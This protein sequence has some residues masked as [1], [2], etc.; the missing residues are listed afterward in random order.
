M[1][2]VRAFRLAYSWH[3]YDGHME[4]PPN[5]PNCHVLDAAKIPQDLQYVLWEVPWMKKLYRVARSFDGSAK[6]FFT[7]FQHLPKRQ[8][9]PDL[10]WTNESVFDHME[11]A[12]SP[13][14]GNVVIDV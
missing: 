12:D 14:E 11:V 13:G 8:T 2:T 7:G 1:N 3:G 9:S 6:M 10:T 4:G 5:L